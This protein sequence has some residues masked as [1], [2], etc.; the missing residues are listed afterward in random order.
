VLDLE[1]AGAY[2]RFAAGVSWDEDERAMEA[3]L[4]VPPGGHHLGTEHTMQRFRTAFHRT[5]L[6]D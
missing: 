3:L 6:L 4:S 2:Q 1:L 5:D